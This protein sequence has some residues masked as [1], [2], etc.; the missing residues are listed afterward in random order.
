MKKILTLIPLLL[1]V[2]SVS[3]CVQGGGGLAGLMGAGTEEKEAPAS[4]LSF[5]DIKVIPTPPIN[6][7][8]NFDFTVQLKNLDERETVRNTDFTLYDTGRCGKRKSPNTD[9][10]NMFPGSTKILKWEIGTPDNEELGQMT[11]ECPLRFKVSY[12]FDANTRAEVIV[13]SK[14][15]LRQVSR[16]GESIKVSPTVT[17]S[18]GP[19]KIDVS[20]ESSQPLRE[21]TTVPFDVVVRNTGGGDVNRLNNGNVSIKISG[22]NVDFSQSWKETGP[23]N[24]PNEG[25]SASKTQNKRLPFI[26]KETPPIRC[27][28]KPPTQTA[29]LKTYVVKVDINGYTYTI[30]DE[31]IVKVEPTFRGG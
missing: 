14:E 28:F 26:D 9:I 2:V 12:N 15:K 1:L 21:N 4:L 24:Y 11:G 17:K 7:D 20:F 23:C 31:K 10:G 29:P 18:R 25:G 30:Y 22:K 8:S 5:T 19:I 13:A 6:A 3:G 27:T 16:T